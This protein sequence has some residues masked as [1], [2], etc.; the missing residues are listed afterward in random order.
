M[1]NKSKFFLAFG[2]GALVGAG[3]A[4][5]FTTEEGKALVEKAKAQAGDLAED[6]KKKVKDLEDELADFMKSDNTQENPGT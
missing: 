1:D 4:A 3:L 5:L 6:L 2:A